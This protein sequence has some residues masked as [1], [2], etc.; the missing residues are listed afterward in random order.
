MSS[1]IQIHGFD[2]NFHFVGMTF[3][4]EGFSDMKDKFSS[5]RARYPIR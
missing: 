1:I 5:Q 3:Q 4:P 2:P